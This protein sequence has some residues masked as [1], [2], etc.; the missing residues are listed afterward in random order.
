MSDEY[1]HSAFPPPPHPEVLLWRYLD[2]EKFDWL[3]SNRRLFMP[4]AQFLGDPLEGTTPNGHAEWWRSLEADTESEEKRQIIRQNQEKI[5]AFAKA[6]RPHYYVSCWHMND[7]ESRKM[8]RCYT[9]SADAVAVATSYQAL[10]A[11]LPEYVE[12]GMVRYIDYSS[13]SLPSLNLFEY[14]THKNI[15][16]DFEREVRAVALPPAT[17]GLGASQF[18]ANHFES[19]SQKGF[20]VFAPEVDVA[21]LIDRVVLHP[22]SSPAFVAK[23]CFACDGAGLP[24][25]IPS[26]FS[27]YGGSSSAL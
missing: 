4:S 9:K 2:F 26:V 15:N 14:I 23:I 16:F 6:F 18:Q 11:S 1:Q 27:N 7:F 10:R 20:L 21:A 8:W 25:P 24:K 3:V 12:I 19:E 22:E 17:E 5:S 13:Q